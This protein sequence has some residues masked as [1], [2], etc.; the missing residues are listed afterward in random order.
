R[1]DLTVATA[2]PAECTI[3][4]LVAPTSALLA[5]EVQLINNYMADNGR[6]LILSEPGGPNLDAVTTRWGLRLLPGVVFDPERAAAGDP[7]SVLVNDFPTESPVSKGVDG[8]ALVTA[9]G[10]T[11]AASQDPGLTVS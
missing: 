5:N 11:T 3:L 9:G 6:M 4:A 10:I 7:T 8:A 2:V 1:L